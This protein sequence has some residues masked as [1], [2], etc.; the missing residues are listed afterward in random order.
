MYVCM[1]I[2]MYV[3]YIVHT[4]VGSYFGICRARSPSSY[5]RLR[6]VPVTDPETPPAG[7]GGGGC[8]AGGSVKYIYI[9]T[10][11]YLRYRGVC[12]SAA[13]RQRAGM[14]VVW[15]KNCRDVCLVGGG[16]SQTKPRVCTCNSTQGQEA[17]R[18][19]IVPSKI[20]CYWEYICW[21]KSIYCTCQDI[22][23]TMPSPLT[24]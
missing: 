3:L 14:R 5:I 15:K 16:G 23:R 9:Y 7:G 6:S 20:V 24:T 4:Y 2:C 11:T 8:L 21:S 22:S 18:D 1:Y 17:A 13:P 12:I 10:S 19:H